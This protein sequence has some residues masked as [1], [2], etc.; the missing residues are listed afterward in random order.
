MFS[1]E[2]GYN[3][4]LRLS[5]TDT[6]EMSSDLLTKDDMRYK[7]SYKLFA[8]S[9]FRVWQVVVIISYEIGKENILNNELS[10]WGLS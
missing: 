7:S 3:S 2:L 9:N 4:K 5:N 10:M 1:E 8:Q 6:P